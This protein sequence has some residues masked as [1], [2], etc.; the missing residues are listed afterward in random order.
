MVIVE[1][2]LY[3]GAPNPRWTLDAATSRALDDAVAQLEAADTGAMRPT[4]LGYRGL[5]VRDE[6][7]IDERLFVGGGHVFIDGRVRIDTES[8]I[9]RW[10]LASAV[11]RIDAPLL[12]SL[13]EGP[14][15]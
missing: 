10:L 1:L 12:R 13:R 4:Q 7:A 8:R 14:P 2:D 9:E 3:S 15:A 11:G 6:R 5:I